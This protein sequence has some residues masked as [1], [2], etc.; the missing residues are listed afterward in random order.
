MLIRRRSANGRNVVGSS[1]DGENVDE[2]LRGRVR[3]LVG[4]GDDQFD[5][6]EPELADLARHLGHVESTLAGR[7]AGVR[8]VGVLPVRVVQRSRLT[9]SRDEN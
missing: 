4:I 8:V 1:A 5:E 2:A 3:R 9:A 7:G 6:V